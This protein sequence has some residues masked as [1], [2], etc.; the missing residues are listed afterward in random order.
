M[1]NSKVQTLSDYI[2]Y[3]KTSSF[4]VPQVSLV[5]NVE[6]VVILDELVYSKYD[7][8]LM[9]NSEMITLTTEEYN[10]YRLDPQALSN[11]LYGTPNLDHLILYLN[12][13]SEFD[14]DIKKITLFDPR[15]KERK[16]DIYER[17]GSLRGW[18]RSDF[19]MVD[20][21]GVNFMVCA[22][23]SNG[24]LQFKPTHNNELDEI[25]DCYINETKTNIENITTSNTSLKKVIHNGQLLIIKD[26]K[27][28]NLMG[29]EVQSVL[30]K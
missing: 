26:G 27:T 24:E 28:Y 13:C 23:D 16:F 19:G 30:E 3:G 22:F 7:D 9:A 1:D 4:S 6:G 5:R 14:F 15:N 29:V 12:R 21:G 18:L 25:E 8:L 11:I 10:R 2:R 20:G 17:F